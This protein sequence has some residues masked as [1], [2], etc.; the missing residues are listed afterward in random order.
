MNG[1]GCTTRQR[2]R[3]A[4]I[5]FRPTKLYGW[6]IKRGCSPWRCPTARAR[7]TRRPTS[8]APT[9]L[10]LATIL[11]RL[12]MYLGVLAYTIYFVTTGA[13]IRAGV[14]G[15]GRSAGRRNAELVDVIDFDPLGRLSG[16]D[17]PF[18]Q[19]AARY[20]RHQRDVCDCLR[21]LAGSVG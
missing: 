12:T 10:A 18:R 8:G 16:T 11:T 2:P 1:R 21:L 5:T 17:S 19:F 13:T 15:R 20:L 4:S 9:S 7:S 14:R 3:S 6:P